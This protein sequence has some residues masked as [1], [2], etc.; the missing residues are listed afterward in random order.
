MPNYATVWLGL[1]WN[2]TPNSFI[3]LILFMARRIVFAILAVLLQDYVITQI[4]ALL[5]SSS[6]MMIALLKLQPY[7]MPH[8]QY[9]QVLN[10]AI[11][12]SSCMVT[13][14]FTPA[15]NILPLEKENVG[16]LM[17]GLVMLTTTVNLLMQVHAIWWQFTF[18]RKR[19]LNYLNYKKG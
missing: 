16:V 17:I 3:Y 2:G 19:R 11:F 5:L 9:L 7:E 12:F 1:K 15:F 6:M 18:N 4:F 8:N 13:L 10:E 14:S